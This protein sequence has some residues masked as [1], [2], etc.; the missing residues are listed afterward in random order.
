MLDYVPLIMTTLLFGLL[1]TYIVVYVNYN[2]AKKKG[3]QIQEK[4]LHKI[5]TIWLA[6][7]ITPV[8]WSYFFFN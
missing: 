5:V 8:I 6:I 2:E 7:F 4:K 3:D 1:V